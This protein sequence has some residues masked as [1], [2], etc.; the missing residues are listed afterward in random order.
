MSDPHEQGPVCDFC[1][2]PVE[3]DEELEPIYVGD[4]PEPQS[5]SF[6][7][8]EKRGKHT[9]NTRVLGQPVGVFMAAYRALEESD[10]TEISVKNVVHEVESVGGEVQFVTEDQ[11]PP[12]SEAPELNYR[13]RTDKVGVGIQVYPNMT[14]MS[15]DAE[16]C[17]TCAEMFRNL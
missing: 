4:P 3:P 11:A 16:V 10:R 12:V 8:V 9:R 2:L 17:D 14:N 13:T 1:D 15:P 5:Q 6:S 7:A